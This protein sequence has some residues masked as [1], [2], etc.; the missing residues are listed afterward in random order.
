MHQVHCV[1]VQDLDEEEM[2]ELTESA[3]AMSDDLEFKDDGYIEL[4]LRVLG[5]MCD[6]QH[7][8]LQVSCCVIIPIS[9]GGESSSISFCGSNVRSSCSSIGGGNITVT[10]QRRAGMVQFDTW[11]SRSSSCS[12]S[13]CSS[14]SIVMA[15][16]KV[17]IVIIIAVVVVVIKV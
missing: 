16:V 2:K 14:S 13:S 5:L 11:N 3:I 10:A 1:V 8:G 12:S 9:V 4:V 6:N 17:I 7:K 15:V